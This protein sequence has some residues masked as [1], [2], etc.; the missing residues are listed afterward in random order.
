M[1]RRLAFVAA[2]LAVAGPASAEPVTKPIRLFNG[3]DLANFYTYLGS[4]TKGGKAY[5]KNNDPEKI[6]S[7]VDADGKPAIRVSGK[8]FG[9]FV[10]EKEYENYHLTVEFKWG[11]E[12]W[13]PREKGARDSG[14][15]LHCVGEDGAASGVWL[16]SVECQMIEGGTGDFILV[17]GKNT[18][19]LSVKVKNIPTGAGDKKSPQPYFDPDGMLTK[20]TGGR[21]NWWG[22]DPVWKDTVGFRGKNDVERL[23]G[24]WNTLECVC[25]GGNITNILNGKVVNAGTECSHTRGKILFQS[26]GAEVFFRRIDLAPVKK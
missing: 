17:K 2:F 26:E 13:P 18:P 1:I 12:T 6:F 5:G 24:E 3:K 10:T 15:L 22:R 8:V 16:E 20:F 4:P 7:V 23:A 21:I 9:C 19:S 14:I 25:D 11:K